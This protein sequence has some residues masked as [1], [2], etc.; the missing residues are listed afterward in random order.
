[1]EGVVVL[2]CC[3]LFGSIVEMLELD[4][5]KATESDEEYSNENKRDGDNSHSDQGKHNF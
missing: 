2:A 4:A 1:M 5:S 3:T